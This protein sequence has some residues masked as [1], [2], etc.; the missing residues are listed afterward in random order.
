MGSETLRRHT[1]NGTHVWLWHGVLARHRVRLAAGKDDGRYGGF[2][3]VWDG[4]SLGRGLKEEG[5][6]ITGGS[7]AGVRTVEDM[8]RQTCCSEAL[9]R[10]HGGVWH[11]CIGSPPG[12]ST[13][14]RRRRGCRSEADATQM[15]RTETGGGGRL[16]QRQTST[17]EARLSDHRRRNHLLDECSETDLGR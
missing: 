15:D 11:Q 9:Q 2:R 6:R 10:K 1:F 17:G 14:G 8:R 4:R 7:Y 12:S 5:K 3:T 16:A 13:D